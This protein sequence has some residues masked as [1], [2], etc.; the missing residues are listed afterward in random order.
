MVGKPLRRLLRHI[1]ISY[2][3]FT[4]AKVEVSRLGM[5]PRYVEPFRMLYTLRSRQACSD[6]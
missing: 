2:S 6:S 5:Q 3:A 1:G 4:S